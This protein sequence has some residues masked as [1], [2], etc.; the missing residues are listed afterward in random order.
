[1]TILCEPAYVNDLLQAVLDSTCECLQNTVYG[2]P[3][4]CFISHTT[5]PDDC[6]DFL[7]IWVEQMLPTYSFPEVSTRVQ[8]CGDVH[9]MVRV[10]MKLLRDCYPVVRDNAQAPFPSPEEMQAAAEGLLIDG[11]VLWC[12]VVDALTTGIGCD[13]WNECLDSLMNEMVPIRP[14][15]GCAGWE[16]AFTLELKGCC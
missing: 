3:G 9:R 14:R 4:S 6:C 13:Q 8:K 12:C 2:T 5:P 16:L 11:N 1:M 7:A 15:G 10:K